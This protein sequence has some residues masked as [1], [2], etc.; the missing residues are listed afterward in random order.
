MSRSPRD[1]ASVPW[2]VRRLLTA[3]GDRERAF[4]HWVSTPTELLGGARGR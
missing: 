4:V 1:R 3:G 2:G